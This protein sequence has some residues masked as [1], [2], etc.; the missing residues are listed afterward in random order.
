[1]PRN[2]QGSK[3][4]RG[5]GTTVVAS[6]PVI[7]ALPIPVA[8]V[9]GSQPG[10]AGALKSFGIGSLEKEIEQNP[11]RFRIIDIELTEIVDS[12]INPKHRQELDEDRLSDILPSVREFGVI[13]PIL[14]CERAELIK[15]SPQLDS[16]TEQGHYVIL[17][18]HRRR[19]ASTLADLEAI[20]AIIRNE[21][22]TARALAQIFLVENS[23][24]LQLTELEEAEGFKRLY[25]DGLSYQEIVDTVGGSVKSKSQVSRRISLLKLT[26][27]GKELLNTRQITADGALTVLAEL[28]DDESRDR[29]LTA[30]TTGDID[31]RPSLKAAVKQE[32]RRLSE[33]AETKALRE[34][35]QQT[36]LPEIDP[37]EHWGDDG[38][39]HRLATDEEIDSARAEKNL[40]GVAIVDGALQYFSVD[41]APAVKAAVAESE[42][43][44][45]SGE[46][47]EIESDNSTAGASKTKSGKKEP[48]PVDL[49]QQRIVQ[50]RRQAHH[51]S[52]AKRKQACQK[53]VA[54]YSTFKDNQRHALIE[55]LTD[56]VLAGGVD[57]AVLRRSEVAQWTGASVATEFDLGEV[58]S[59]DRPQASRLALAATL[60]SIEAQAAD[61]R[62]L[63]GRPW[64]PVVVR[65]ITRLVELGYHSLSPYEEDKLQN[66]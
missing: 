24:R 4:P 47:D 33:I 45:D 38:W 62:Y 57:K 11:D 42:A 54:D 48:A 9:A 12:P 13:S 55:I 17:A 50:E 37:K 32:V 6:P 19:A 43:A 30:A 18:G 25:D 7:P 41:L 44:S 59:S 40:A 34:Q 31:E 21:Y 26:P 36:G 2:N 22:A 49:E 5:T 15:N 60:A 64:P 16:D 65:Y 8:G 63:G 39:Q 10:G 56:G 29:A 14:V 52:A 46:S 23:G 1:M 28:P 61:E 58:I 27:L 51:D 3:G 35:I 20:P 66:L 53:I